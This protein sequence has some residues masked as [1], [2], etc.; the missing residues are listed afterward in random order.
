MFP[1]RKHYNQFIINF[2]TSISIFIRQV[3][4]LFQKIELSRENILFLVWWK[5]F[6]VSSVFSGEFFAGDRISTPRLVRQERRE[7]TARGIRSIFKATAIFDSYSP[8]PWFR[9]HLFHDPPASLRTH[10]HTPAF[11]D[12]RIYTH[13]CTH[14]H[15]GKRGKVESTGARLRFMD[16]C[17]MLA[18]MPPISE[19][20][21]CSTPSL[22]STLVVRALTN[23]PEIHRPAT[24]RND[25]D[26]EAVKT[27]RFNALPACI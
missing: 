15:A 1:K 7:V 6:P 5:L 19:H 21:L 8:R 22:C 4:S 2:N 10:T 25:P 20:Q 3:N 17:T 23:H 27:T 12:T 18:D 11:H 16:N 13:A 9:R 14:T 26:F 24:R